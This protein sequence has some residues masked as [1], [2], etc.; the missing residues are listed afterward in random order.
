MNEIP[1]LLAQRVDASL[2]AFRVVVVH[3]PRQSGKS[4]LART[5]ATA[6]GG[7]YVTLDDD[8]ILGLADDDPHAFVRAFRPP[9][10]VDEVQRAGDRLVRAIKIAVDD[11]TNVPG[12][13][14][15]TGSSNFLTVPTI[16]ESLA[17]RAA[18][19]TLWPFSQRELRAAS[20]ATVSPQLGLS[21]NAP[22]E[23]NGELGGSRDSETVIEHWFDPDGMSALVNE[24]ATDRAHY[25]HLVC[26][27]G[28]P[29]V[30][31]TG[32]R[33]RSRWFA[34]YAETVIS[35]DILQ[36]GDIRRAAA[37]PQV[38]RLAAAQTAGELN[39]SQWSQRLGL[40]R[41]TVHSYLGWLRT[42]FLVNELPAWRRNRVSRA[43]QRPKLHVADSGLAAGL[44]GIDHGSLSALNHPMLGPLVETFTANEIT[45]LCSAADL[46]VMP[47]HYR[48]KHG[49]EVN[50][51]LE[52]SDG[53]VVAVEIKA[54][55]SP[56]RKDLRHLASF[57]DALDAV[58]PGA[59]RAGVLLHLGSH[60][61]PH[62]DRLRS[63]PIDS[64]WRPLEVTAKQ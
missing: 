35:R 56:Q 59:F 30:Q 32:P 40:D 9:V 4:T 8:G 60:H 44:L 51:V 7:T 22:S 17:G 58:E 29:E 57:R 53:A 5:L 63:M 41:S 39:V 6:R 25:L 48:D 49:R 43:L 14:L 27:G 38:L 2:D 37:L 54:T 26:T 42:V 52:R 11:G 55:S 50:L 16:G 15:L 47:F 46:T 34:S 20:D 62:G 23:R 24:A 61:L 3:G 19:F 45:R 10:V 28:F 1:R 36:L 33:D 12:R 64:L 18:L 31:A 21:A 13:F